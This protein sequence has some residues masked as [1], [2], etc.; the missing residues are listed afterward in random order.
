MRRNQIYTECFIVPS[1]YETQIRFTDCFV[2]TEYFGKVSRED[3]CRVFF[4]LYLVFD[5]RYTQILVVTVCSV[6]GITRVFLISKGKTR[7][8]I[9]I[10]H[11]Q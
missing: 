8:A 6:C 3:M 1:I 11:V 9:A 10:D 4:S 7:G 5:T 2:S